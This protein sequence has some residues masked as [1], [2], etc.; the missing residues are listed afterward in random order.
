MNDAD[1]RVQL[2]NHSIRLN[3]LEEHVQQLDTFSDSIQA[4]TMSVNEL[5]INMSHMVNEQREQ[6]ER[7]KALESIPTDNWKT[8]KKTVITSIISTISGALAVGL[9]F[10]LASY[11]R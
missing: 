1:V 2:E 4:L 8:A 3:N 6:G 5:A 9:I 11:L 7:V 10:L